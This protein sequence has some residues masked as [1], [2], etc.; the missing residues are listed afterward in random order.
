MPDIHLPQLEE[1]D[2]PEAAEAKPAEVHRS[3]RP[4]LW[5]LLLEVLLI[6]MGVFLGLAGEQWRESARQR[7]LAHDSLRRFRTELAANRQSVESV[8]DYHA[9][10]QKA[11]A[12]YFSQD[13]QHRKP[14]SGIHGLDPASFQRTAWDLAVATQSLTNIDPQLTFSLARVYNLQARYEQ[15]TNSMLQSLYIRPPDE[16]PEAFLEA[17]QVY[18]GD[19]VY[20]EPVLLKQYD[21][22]IPQIERALGEK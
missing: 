2:E 10:L 15:L 17:L 22:L 20:E 12:E 6:S 5:R 11:L 16:N 8:K 4:H 1:H 7:E 19:I 9:K 18:Y 21:E 3:H 14:F 13:R